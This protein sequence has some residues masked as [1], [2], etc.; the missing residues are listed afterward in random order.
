VGGSVVDLRVGKR[1]RLKD[2][3]H[4]SVAIVGKDGNL[5]GNMN[6]KTWEIVSAEG[7]FCCSNHH[8][9]R[10]HGMRWE[11]GIVVGKHFCYL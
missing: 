11:V 1:I 8:Y 6:G 7:C 2:Y 5:L 3:L 4:K 10:V 9:S